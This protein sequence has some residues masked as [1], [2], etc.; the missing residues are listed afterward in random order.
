MLR[1]VRLEHLDEV[2]V[3]EKGEI[4]EEVLEKTQRSLRLDCEE[5]S[6]R[7]WSSFLENLLQRVIVLVFVLPSKLLFVARIILDRLCHGLVR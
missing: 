7:S 3:R 2:M 6:A 4:R 5:V 1:F